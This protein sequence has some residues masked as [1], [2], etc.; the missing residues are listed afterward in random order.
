MSGY[1]WLLAVCLCLTILALVVAYV[2]LSVSLSNLKEIRAVTLLIARAPLPPDAWRPDAP[3][4]ARFPSP[5]PPSQQETSPQPA[6]RLAPD[7]HGMSE[8]NRILRRKLMDQMEEKMG[9]HWADF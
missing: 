7:E 6:S 1:E 5:P 4:P 8:A 3:P 9:D 2:C